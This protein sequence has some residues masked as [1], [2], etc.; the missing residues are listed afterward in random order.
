V[1]STEF[2]KCLR[3]IVTESWRYNLKIK[4]K[5]FILPSCRTVEQWWRA[6]QVSK[7]HWIHACHRRSN[8]VLMQTVG[9][10][11]KYVCSERCVGL[12]TRGRYVGGEKWGGEIAVQCVQCDEVYGRVFWTADSHTLAVG[13]QPCQTKILSRSYPPSFGTVGQNPM[14][15]LFKNP[16]S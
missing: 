15:N 7:W 10:L 1:C 2:R 9:E 14:G 6:V 16:Y 11:Y 5:R 8:P 4:K 3:L 12:E 13:G